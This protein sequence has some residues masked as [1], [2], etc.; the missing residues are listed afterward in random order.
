MAKF[1]E[2]MAARN[3]CMHRRT[4]YEE[5]VNFL[6]Q[7]VED[8]VHKPDRTMAT[9][10]IGNVPQTTIREVMEG[11]QAG[12]IDK[13]TKQISD[14]ESMKVEDT[15]GKEQKAQTPEAGQEGSARKG[16]GKTRSIKITKQAG[17]GAAGD[18]R[19]VSGAGANVRT[20]LEKPT[21]AGEE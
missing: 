21:G 18:R 1:Q 17:R 14:I 20:A 19:K 11:L 15:R 5:I 12:N 3:E 7:F 10:D 4:V 2:M 13:L 9:G 8:E 16:D 6:S